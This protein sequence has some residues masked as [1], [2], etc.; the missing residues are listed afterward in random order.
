LS[1]PPPLVLEARVS[2]AALAERVAYFFGDRVKFVVD[3]ERLCLALGADAH[4]DLAPLLVATGS[5]PEHL[6]G[7]SYYPGRGPERCI[8]F[9][10]QINLRPAQGNVGPEIADPA[11]RAK[12]REIAFALIGKGEAV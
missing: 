4:S 5:R 11:V 7:A 8:E 6:W 9:K 2:P 3:I 12:V 10:S 1:V